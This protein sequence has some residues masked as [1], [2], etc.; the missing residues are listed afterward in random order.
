MSTSAGNEVARVTA[1]EVRERL[2]RGEPLAIVDARS[3]DS[4]S[5]SD[6]QAAGSIRVPPDEAAQRA[7]AVPQD[8]AVIAYCT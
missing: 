1:Q 8:R 6:T 2:A 5:K 7:A 4:W 3:A